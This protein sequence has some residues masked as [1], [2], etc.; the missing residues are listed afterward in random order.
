MLEPSHAR[1]AQRLRFPCRIA[2][3]FEEVVGATANCHVGGSARFRLGRGSD[4]D[5]GNRTIR[6]AKEYDEFV[7][8][9][10]RN[11]V[12]DEHEAILAGQKMFKGI[13]SKV[14]RFDGVTGECQDALTRIHKRL[15]VRD[16]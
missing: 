3:T 14:Y 4:E 10:C 5:Y 6:C 13:R 9:Y 1:G 15:I 12:S 8:L 2:H 7:A 16:I 11:R